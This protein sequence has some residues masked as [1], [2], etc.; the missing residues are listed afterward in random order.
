MLCGQTW[1]KLGNVWLGVDQIGPDLDQLFAK[2]GL[3]VANLGPKCMCAGATPGCGPHLHRRAMK[4]GWPH[5]T[6]LRGVPPEEGIVFHR[7]RRL[8]EGGSHDAR[9]EGS[10]RPARE[11]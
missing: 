10:L 7:R 9:V 2:S 5:M 3:D 8:G 6:Q 4:V 1:T 11:H